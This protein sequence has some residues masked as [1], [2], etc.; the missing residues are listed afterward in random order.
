VTF[1]YR[2]NVVVGTVTFN[3]APSAT[4]SLPIPWNSP[5]PLVRG[6]I[7]MHNPPAGWVLKNSN[8]N[9]W[10]YVIPMSAE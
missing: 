7:P 6:A 5:W 3:T 2:G 1:H 4:A 8:S 9:T 10:H